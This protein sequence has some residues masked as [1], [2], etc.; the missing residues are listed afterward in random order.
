MKNGEP[1]GNIME[2]PNSSFL[3]SLDD[4]AKLKKDFVTSSCAMHRHKEL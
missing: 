2:L 4:H 3:P 1:I